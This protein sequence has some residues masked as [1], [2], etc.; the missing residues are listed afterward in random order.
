MKK[1]FIT[2]VIIILTI[3][4]SIYGSDYRIMLH[5]TENRTASNY[6][7]N[8]SNITA[9]GAIS[10]NETKC[11]SFNPT[12]IT[13]VTAASGGSG[14]LEYKWQSKTT[15]S[16]VDISGA[17]SADYDPP[18]ITQ[19]TQYQRLAKRSTCTSYIASNTITKTVNAIPVANAGNDKTICNAA[20]T[21]ITATATGGAVPYTYLWSDGL[22]NNAA[23]TVSPAA[24]KTYTVTITDNS[25]CFSSDAMTVTVAISSSCPEICGNGIDDDNDGLTD[26]FDSNCY[27]AANS[28]QADN[29]SDG[30][31]NGCDLDDDNDGI[32][33]EDEGCPTC[34]GGIFIN[35]DFEENMTHT[36]FIQTDESNIPGWSTTSSDNK[37]EI[38]KTGFLSVNSQT[39]NYHAEIN[40]TQNAALYQRVCSKPGTVFSWSVWHRGRAGTDVAV[41]K[42]GNSL[43]TSSIQKTMTTGNTAWQQYSGTYTVPADEV[44]TYFIF[45]A[46]STA[47]NISVGN[48]VDNIQIVEITAGICLDTDNDGIPNYLDPDSDNDTCPDAIEGSANVLAINIDGNNKITG[49]VNT[50]GIPILVNVGQG[51]GNSQ[52]AAIVSCPEICNDG[53]DNDGDQLIDC[54]DSDCILPPATTIITD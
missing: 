13:S 2:L 39:G 12:T 31:G 44:E 7:L 15:G 17:T 21:T 24:T 5:T 8:C 42:I 14:T 35:G 18:T 41:V 38:W 1:K 19:T 9:G 23:I 6:N 53:V 28:G 45:E 33:D 50:Q 43:S 22:G 10:G 54:D 36:N 46:I 29:D 27:L 32:T 52:D 3:T 49:G 47:S 30:I 40:A 20:T 4:T 51:Y 37:I 34:S 11:G 25:G 48:F 16:W 26:C